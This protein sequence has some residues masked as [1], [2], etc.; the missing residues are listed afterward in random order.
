MKSRILV[1]LLSVCLLPACFLDQQEPKPAEKPASPPNQGRVSMED[2]RGYQAVAMFSARFGKK[3]TAP[4]AASL[5][6]YQLTNLAAAARPEAPRCEFAK[7]TKTPTE[8][9]EDAAAYLN[10]GTMAFGPALQSS[11]TQ[12]QPDEH[13]KYVSKLEPGVPAGLYSVMATGAGEIAKFGDILSMPEEIREATGNNVTFEDGIPLL[14]GAPLKVSWN[15]PAMENE[16]NFMLLDFY[17][18]TQTEQFQI[19]CVAM[20]AAFGSVTPK[21]TW[22]I[23]ASE[24]AKLPVTAAA[25]IYFV[26]AH[27]RNVASSQMEVQFQGIRTYLAAAAIFQN[28]DAMP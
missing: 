28:P 3:A 15:K 2:V 13:N 26:R 7:A 6:S 8:V 18:E 22:E 19:H 17:A 23:P 27:V 20:E 16:S 5:R 12:V 24:M 11:G 25:A 21:L 4:Q 10:V 1:W 14:Q 9:R